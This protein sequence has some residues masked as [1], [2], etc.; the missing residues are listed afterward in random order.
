MAT[1]VWSCV[2]GFSAV[3]IARGSVTGDAL[4]QQGGDDHHDDQQHQ[5]HV[6][7]RRNVDVGLDTSGAA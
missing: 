1:T 2:S 6:H 4:L 3:L 7:E 5:H